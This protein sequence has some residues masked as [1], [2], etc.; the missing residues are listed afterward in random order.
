MGTHFD[1]TNFFK[2]RREPLIF[3]K[4]KKRKKNLFKYNPKRGFQRNTPGYFLILILAIWSFFPNRVMASVFNPTGLYANVSE[5]IVVVI[6]WDSK[7]GKKSFG[8]GSIIHK[9]GLVLTNAHVIINKENKKPFKILYIILKPE[10]ITGNFKK[11]TSKI[12]RSKLINYSNKLDLALIKIGPGSP[13]NFRTINIADS[14]LTSIGDP[15]LAIG[16]P[17]NGGLWSLT[18]G[19]I[20]SKINNFQ[21]KFGK[22]VFQTE[23]SLNRG[24]SGGPLI[25]KNGHLV[26][27]NSNFSRVNKEGLPVIGINFSIMSNV[28]L[29]WIKSLNLNID[30]EQEKQKTKISAIQEAN[31]IP[32]PN[33]SFKNSDLIS[34]SKNNKTPRPPKNQRPS[35]KEIYNLFESDLEKMMILM[36]EKIKNKKLLSKLK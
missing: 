20:T 22:N 1:Y 21:K 15:V 26:G 14:S 3:S 7:K 2:Y 24:N 27:I 18:T 36:R 17:E 30:L 31:I 25:N 16:H 6:G 4:N 10:K 13:D 32:L 34:K 9:D 12:Y 5:S 8:T 33:L 35:K 19:T 11:D 29:K 23:T 28:A